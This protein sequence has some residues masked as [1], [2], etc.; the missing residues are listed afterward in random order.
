[1]AIHTLEQIYSPEE[2]EEVARLNGDGSYTIGRKED[3]DIQVKGSRVSKTHARIR[4]DGARAYLRDLDSSNGTVVNGTPLTDELLLE[5]EQ[6]II[7]GISI[8]RY[9]NI[10]N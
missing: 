10:E 1:M 8:C 4:I 7:F 5:N 6:L 9:R 2:I 3:C